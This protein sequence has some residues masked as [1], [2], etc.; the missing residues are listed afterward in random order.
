MKNAFSQLLSDII[1]QSEISKNEMIRACDIDRSSF[2]KFLNGS[3]LPTAE[4]FSRIC[5]KLRF[6]PEEEKALRYEY[7]R[8]S[9]GEKSV[10]AG[11]R[12]TDLLWKLEDGTQTI[13]TN[14]YSSKGAVHRKGAVM[15]AGKEEVLSLVKH[16]IMESAD[17]DKDDAYV[18]LFLPV[19]VEEHGNWI[20]GFLRTEQGR[21]V[22][23]RQLI[24]LPSHDPQADQTIM[25]RVRA[26][27]ICSVAAPESYSSYY[28]YAYQPV[29]ASIGAFLVY[30]VI[31]N[32]RVI[33][34]N[35]RMDRA[36]IIEDAQCC[37]DYRNHFETALSS[38]RLLVR[39]VKEE[40][41]PQQL[42]IPIKFRYGSNKYPHDPFLQTEVIYVSPAGIREFVRTGQYVGAPDGE[43]LS[44]EERIEMLRKARDRIGTKLYLIDE[45]SIPPAR[46]WNIALA[47][48]EMI[49]LFKKG[50]GYFFILSETN[51]VNDFYRFMEGLP[52]SGNLI[53]NE[54]AQ[55]IMEDLIE[56]MSR[57]VG[58]AKN[59][60]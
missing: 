27:L 30:S 42:A 21:Q 2:F 11:S 18:D 4:Q 35:E 43:N 41:L 51:V 47:G 25:E 56:R 3:R 6:S 10:R 44:L 49:I 59:N 26:A 53:R 12:I 52:D 48:R 45:K 16:S 17:Q 13:D 22:K 24:E 60:Y 36:I 57:M 38:A 34:L 9:K 19:H 50:S 8:V 33:L 7:A 5:T 1:S 55:E 31:L 58:E 39:K 29:E 20:A 54:L 37:E 15:A 23:V 14:K 28:Y 46:T 40:D 32:R